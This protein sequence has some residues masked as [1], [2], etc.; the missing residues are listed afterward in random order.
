MNSRWTVV[1]LSLVL[2]VALHTEVQTQY[3]LDLYTL[4]QVFCQFPFARVVPLDDGE[5]WGLLYADTYGKLHLL[6][7]T[8]K[9]WKLEWELTNL[10]AKI[11]KYFM[12]DIEGDG[13][14]E[15][16]VAT[17]NGRILIY[18]MDDYQSVWENLEDNFRAISTMEIADI[19]GDP[20]PEFIILA[21][22]RI[23]VVD[24][25]NKGRQWTSEREFDATEIVIDNVDKDDQMEIILNTGIVIDTRFFNIELEWDKLFGE[26]IM[27]F[28]MNNDGYPEV[29]GEFS[30]YS[31]RIFDI[32]A[33]REVW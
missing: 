21:D 15:L 28:D 19:D 9:G 12:W 30:D 25:L 4:Q 27:V 23:Y 2:M 10:G 33:Q 7:S 11:R 13:I 8:K 20:Q 26:R 16:V 3:E 5:A 6:R 17:V 29:I 18:R 24:G 1:L 32:Y 22:R 14:F 31:L